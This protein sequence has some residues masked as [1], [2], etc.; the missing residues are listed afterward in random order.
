VSASVGPRT[1]TA[2][3]PESAHVSWA[4][5]TFAAFTQPAFRVVWLGSVMAFLA[6][7][8]ANTTQGVVAYELTGSSR[9]VGAVL[10]GQGLAQTFLNP[11][12]GAIADRFSR[13]FLI[14]VAQAVIGAVML[15]VAIL[16]T[17]D[18]IS[19]LALALTSFTVGSMFSFLGPTRTALIGE[20]M[21]EGRIGNAMALVQV[22]G[23]FARI[24]APPLAGVLISLSFIGSAGTFYI[25]AAIFILVLATLYRLPPSPPRRLSGSSM[26]DDIIGGLRYTVSRP[27]LLHAVVSFHVVL[28]LGFSQ[29][30]LMPGF[31]TGVL[32]SNAAGLGLLLG[33][34]AAGGLVTSV[35]VASLADSA[36]AQLYLTLSSLTAG[37]ALVLL[38]LAP[39]LPLAMLAMLFV[40]GGTSGF[41]TLNNAYAL[42]LTESAF[43]GRVIGIIFLAWGLINIVSLPIGYLADQF[44]ERAVLS[45]LGVSLCAAVVLLAA[46]GRAVGRRLPGGDSGQ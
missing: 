34:A 25:I 24:A 21:P 19:I 38:G 17:V 14:L 37:V 3:L 39:S 33:T 1:P 27:Y 20:V 30:V 15:T 13:R 2:E 29:M 23:N 45:G 43:Y 7:N 12:G 22:G 11:F 32:G 18:R 10:F 40:G 26:L 6:F 35:F 4:A 16:I 36:R 9:A 42:R 41:Q 5:S 31:V 46:W 28:L 44:G 8:M